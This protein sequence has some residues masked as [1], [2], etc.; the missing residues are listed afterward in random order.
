MYNTIRLKALPSFVVAILVLIGSVSS[1]EEASLDG[2]LLTIPVLQVDL[3]YYRI[4][5]ALVFG[6]DPLELSL[7]SAEELSNASATGASSFANN[8]L[9]VPS[10]THDDISYNLQLALIGQDPVVFRLASAAVNEAPPTTPDSSALLGPG[11]Q[12]PAYDGICD[13]I[14]SG[15]YDANGKNWNV[16]GTGY[17]YFCLRER[18]VV[19]GPWVN[20]EEEGR[21]IR[22][23]FDSRYVT[24][25]ENWVGGDRN[26]ESLAVDIFGEEDYSAGII[27]IEETLVDNKAIGLRIERSVEGGVV[28]ENRSQCDGTGGFGSCV[29][30]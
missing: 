4:Q 12:A 23:D 10:L 9:T 16:D 19:E 29:P 7:H 15:R 30:I 14:N 22:Y 27:A 6:T 17:Y 20:Y 25:I 26:G 1:A 28:F 18:V 5:L 2:N 11:D 21:F 3:Q 8:T 13:G 24:F